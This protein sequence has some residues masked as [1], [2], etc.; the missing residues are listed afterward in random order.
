MAACHRG[1]NHS[2]LDLRVQQHDRAHQLSLPQ[3]AY[4][5]QASAIP[6]AS[7]AA[8]E[9]PWWKREWLGAN[10]GS[11]LFYFERDIVCTLQSH[12]TDSVNAG[13]QTL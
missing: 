3:Q 12:L 1:K 11:R 7:T 13:T 10:Y 4:P 8:P 6:S 5:R 9:L 2:N